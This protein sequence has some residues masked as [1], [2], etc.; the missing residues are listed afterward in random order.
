M[1]QKKIGFFKRLK[2]AV[3]N[4]D[5]YSLFVEEKVSIAIKYLL[6]IALIFTII[7]TIAFSIGL[8]NETNKAIQIFKDEFPEFK[9]ENNSLIIEENKKFIKEDELGLFKLIVDSE[10]ESLD[11]IENVNEY[12]IVIAL[13]KNGIV[14][15]NSENVEVPIT[16]EQLNQ[17][18]N[19]QDTNKQS[20]IDFTSSEYMTK[21]YIIFIAI[22]LLYLF[23]GY[24]IKIFIDVLTLSL[25]G[26]L[27]SRIIGVKFKYKSIFNM[28]VY[29]LT[30][31]II[32]SLI[33]LVVNIFTGFQIV[34]FDIAYDRNI[35]Y[36]YCY[37]NAY[38]KIRF[39]KTA[40]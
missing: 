38:D 13:L 40:N 33:Y 7:L 28:S 11:E 15:K 16:Y 6:K 14:M 34:Y 3:T 25:I 9:F 12:Q 1:E 20:I 39:N 2:I 31:S 29:A 8:I 32:L 26:F 17:N 23:I 36:L 19:I 37:S 10:K 24:F 22:I 18:Y 27:L 30:L 35:V 21:T 4:F 5:E